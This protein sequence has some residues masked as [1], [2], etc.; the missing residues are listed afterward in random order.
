MCIYSVAGCCIT[1]FVKYELGS[2]E[3]GSGEI[4]VRKQKGVAIEEGLRNLERDRIQ[5]AFRIPK[6]NQ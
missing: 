4:E 1:I 2:L 6:R 3:L 5:V